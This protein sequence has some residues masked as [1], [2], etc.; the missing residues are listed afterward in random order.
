[1]L[2]VYCS[3][4]F[5]WPLH[6]RYRHG[7]RLERP[8]NTRSQ[9]NAFGS[10]SVSEVGG[11]YDAYARFLAPHLE[12]ETGATVIVENWT[13][14]GGLVALNR[15]SADRS[16]GLTL[17]LINSPSAIISQILGMEGVRYNLRDLVW[18][19][20]VLAER[21]VILASPVSP[22][23]SLADLVNSDRT[24]RW[25]SPGVTANAGIAALI[26]QALDLKSKIIVG[27]KGTGEASLAALRGEADLVAM[28]ETS[29]YQQAHNNG[30]V[31]IAVVGTGRSTLLPDVP[32]VAEQYDLSPGQAWWINY[33]AGVMEAGRALATSSHIPPGDTRN[34]FAGL[35][36]KF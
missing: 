30:I 25:A 1:M 15:L 34:I 31:P 6:L 24:V 19:G 16:E 9:V 23:R 3:R 26:S 12:R 10:W 13:G 29:A 8:R 36:R 32:T 14:G 2:V 4:W 21:N 35:W 11:G 7:R 17:M 22:Y 33:A 18:L 20:R 27:Y 28:S 5:F